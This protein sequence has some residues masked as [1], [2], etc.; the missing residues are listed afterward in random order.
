ML[1]ISELRDKKVTYFVVVY[2]NLMV[3]NKILYGFATIKRKRKKSNRGT[4]NKQQNTNF[5]EIQQLFILQNKELL[6]SCA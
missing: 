3:D 1:P 2:K 4:L 6:R 5:N